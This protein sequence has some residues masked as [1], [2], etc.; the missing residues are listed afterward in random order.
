MLYHNLFTGAASH[1]MF[2][3]TS[4][5][6]GAYLRRPA[7]PVTLPGSQAWLNLQCASILADPP[8]WS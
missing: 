4:T 5:D 8:T 3:M 1:N 2:V 6:S 7:I